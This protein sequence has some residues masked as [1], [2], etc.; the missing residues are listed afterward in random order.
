MVQSK[1]LFITLAIVVASAL[2]LH[3]DNEPNAQLGVESAMFQREHFSGRIAEEQD[4]QD[5][6]NE[7]GNEEDRNEEEDREEENQE[8][9]ENREEEDKG[10][11]G[12]EQ[13][14]EE[15]D[16]GEAEDN[17]EEYGY[18]G[19]EDGENYN[20]DGNDYYA[21]SS[22][23]YGGVKDVAVKYQVMQI[24]AFCIVFAALLY[25]VCYVPKRKVTDAELNEDLVDDDEPA[26]MHV[27]MTD[28]ELVKVPVDEAVMA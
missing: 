7:E 14:A 19:G 5:E 28:D 22:S 8:E 21:S 27:A 2:A 26:T 23:K 1:L 10:D 17:G 13:D 11:E 25:A 16:G 12:E 15:E 6:R 3:S 9:E 20:D 18:G 4:Q 24:S